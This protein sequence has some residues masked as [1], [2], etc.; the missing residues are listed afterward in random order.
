MFRKPLIRVA[1]VLSLMAGSA[2]AATLDPAALL[3]DF[4]TIALGN[5]NGSSETEGTVFVGGNLVSNGYGVNPKNLASGT[6]GAVSGSLI[7]GGNVSGNPINVG[8]GNVVIGGTNSA[9]INRNGGGSLTTGASIDVADVATAMNG[10]STY[11]S[12]FA[13]TAGAMVNT[14]DQNLKS[15]TSGAGGTGVLSGVAV[16]N[17]T[18]NQTAKLLGSGNLASLNL[19]A[20]V[21][22]IVNLAGSNLTISGNFNQ[23]NSTVLFN[24][25]EATS[26]TIGNTFGFGILAP[27]ADIFANAG[28]NDGVVVGKNITQRIEFRPLNNRN[29]TGNLPTQ[30]STVPLPAPILLLAGG[31]LALF[32]MRRR[33]AA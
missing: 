28:G 14:A 26:L 23:D 15:L 27:K 4:N 3:R 22:T 24:F 1:T 11:L 8:A 16:L 2:G 30:V 13:T 9:V 31:L 12:S 7:V 10:L 18:T 29:F 19:T 33:K 32:G 6:V 21:T 5:L 20:G 17:L 25:Y